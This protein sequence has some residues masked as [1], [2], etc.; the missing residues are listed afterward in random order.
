MTVGIGAAYNGDD[1][2]VV[3]V[4]DRMVTTGAVEHEHSDGKLEMVSPGNPAVAAVAAGTL[5]YADELYYQVGNRII[6]ESPDTVQAVGELFVDEMHAII[7]NEADN[8][9]LA[10]YDLTLNQLTNQGVPLSDNMVTEFMSQISDLKQDIQGGTNMLIAG[11]DDEH[12]AQI[13]EL[14]DGSLTRHRSLGFQ[15]IGSGAGSAS[16]TFMRN[17]Y[18]PEGLED[19][20]MLAADAKNQ[21]GE[22]QGVGDNMDIA[23]V[24]DD[25][26]FLDTDR[27][28]NIQE[29]IEDVREAERTA[30]ES[31]INDADIE[32]LR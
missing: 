3:L 15:C 10:D 28:K 21:A 5:S 20:L 30:R 23:V 4:A 8:K 22:A 18:D 24:G 14:R 6:D 29:V 17:G 12:G 31:T 16:L 27:I 2:A 9:I 7:R 32:P 19:A 26:R 1:P 13:L 11:V 25:V